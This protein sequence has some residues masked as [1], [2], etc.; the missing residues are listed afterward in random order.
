[1]GRLFWKFFLSILLAQVAATIGI[2]GTIWLRD[3]ARMQQAARRAARIDTGPPAEFMI[4]AAAATLGTAAPT[5]CATWSPSDAAT[6]FTCSTHRPRHAGPGGA[7]PKLRAQ[8]ERVL[9][10]RRVAARPCARLTGAGRRAATWPS[11]R[12][13]ATRR[14]R[15]GRARRRRGPWYGPRGPGGGRRRPGL[16]ARPGFRRPDAAAT[17]ADAAAR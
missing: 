17:S 7:R 14:P 9:E 16:A 13:M 2:G 12:A 1:M 11:P 15:S 10:E 5:R 3:Q 4:D 6:A 8:A